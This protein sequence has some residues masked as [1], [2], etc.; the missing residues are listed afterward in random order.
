MLF[1]GRPLL[2]SLA[3]AI[4]IG[5]TH[6]PTLALPS[7]STGECKKFNSIEK[8]TVKKVLSCEKTTFALEKATLTINANKMVYENSKFNT[9]ANRLFALLVDDAKKAKTYETATKKIVAKIT[10][11]ISKDKKSLAKINTKKIKLCK[12]SKSSFKD[13]EKLATKCNEV[14]LTTEEMVGTI[15]H[16]AKAA[17]YEARCDQL[18]DQANAASEAVI[19][20]QAELDDYNEQLQEYENDKDA[21]LNEPFKKKLAAKRTAFNTNRP[22]LESLYDNQ[23]NSINAAAAPICEEAKKLNPEE[24]EENDSS[25]E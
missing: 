16:D 22:L 6:S 1:A 21:N 14:A 15:L 9:E 19:D 8:A 7:L 4:L 13:Y 20:L 2:R 10:A 3:I 17:I 11:A 25:S 18:T 24:V 5:I 23:G 12:D